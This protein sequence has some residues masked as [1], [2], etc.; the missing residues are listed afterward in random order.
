MKRMLVTF[1]LAATAVAASAQGYPTKPITLIVPFAA[2]GPTDVVAR[3]VGQAMTKTLG[4]AVII[5]NKLGAGGTLAAGHVAKA[6]PDGYTLLIHHNG[7]ATAPALYRKLTFNPM[8][9][10]EYV[11]QAGPF[12]LFRV[13]GCAEG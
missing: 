6:A 8:T 1:A 12:R 9:D 10:F 4:Q 5:E 7:M 11:T 2:G 3:A 13:V